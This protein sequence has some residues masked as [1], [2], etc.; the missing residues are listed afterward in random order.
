MNKNFVA[1]LSVIYDV[2]I[3]LEDSTAALM[4]AVQQHQEAVDKY[5]RAIW[6]ELASLNAVALDPSEDDLR[7]E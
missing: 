3:G 2:V 4:V 1:R 6:G 5:C 7:D